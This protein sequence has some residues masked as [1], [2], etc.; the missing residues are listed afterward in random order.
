VATI[1]GCVT[2]SST[3]LTPTFKIRAATGGGTES[4]YLGSVS[5]TS[6]N[7][8][9]AAPLLVGSVTSTTT[10]KE[11]VERAVVN[12]GSSS[13]VTNQ[14]GAWVSSVGNIASNRCAV[15]MAT[16]EFSGTPVCVATYTGVET[17]TARSI[18][19]NMVS[20]TSFSIGCTFQTGGTTSACSGTDPFQVICMGPNQ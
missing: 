20:S 7:T 13:T 10:G 18:E 6:L 4:V 14:S 19:V 17:S 12:C 15:T 3:S 5:V 9:V 8:P 1:G 2:Y 16:G 11:H